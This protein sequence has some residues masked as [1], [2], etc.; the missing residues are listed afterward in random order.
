MDEIKELK[1][2]AYELVVTINHYTRE[3]QGIEAKIQQLSQPKKVEDETPAP[4]KSK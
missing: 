2:K 4:K 3:L 1:A